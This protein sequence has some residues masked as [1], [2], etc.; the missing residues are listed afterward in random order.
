MTRDFFSRMAE[1]KDLPAVLD[2]YNNGIEERIATFETRPRTL[3][4]LRPWLNSTHPFVVTLER[5]KV[6]AFAV[7]FP[8]SSRECYSGIAEFSIYVDES[9]RGKGVGRIT[10]EKLLLESEKKGFWK[11]VSRIF[12]ENIQS[13][14]LMKSLGFREVGVYENHARLDGKWRDTVI[15]EYIFTKNVV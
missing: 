4:D 10:M 3:M 2:I 11:L 1:S 13:R 14:K 15:V 9:Y 5:D 12:S 8:Y 7:A 6:V